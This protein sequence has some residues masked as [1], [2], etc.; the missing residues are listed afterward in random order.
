MF[1]KIIAFIVIHSALLMSAWAN[2]FSTVSLHGKVVTPDGAPVPDVQVVLLK[3]TPNAQGE[4]QTKGPVGRVA[5]PQGE[6]LF[7]NL[8]VEEHARYRLGTRVNGELMSSDIFILDGTQST[9]EM[10]LPVAAAPR[11]EMMPGAPSGTHGQ[12]ANNNANAEPVTIRGKILRKD[13]SPVPDVNVVLLKFM[14]DSTGELQTNG[15]LARVLAHNGE[16]LFEKIPQDVK[17]AYQLGTSIDGELV[18]TDYFFMTGAT[19]MEIDLP[20]PSVTENADVLEIRQESVFLE[21]G[22]GELIVTE[23]MNVSNGT[24][25]RVDT[26]RHPILIKMPGGYTQFIMH[27]GANENEWSVVEG[28]LQLN[29]VFKPGTSQIVFQYRLPALWGSIS[30]EKIF[31]DK[32]QSREIFIQGTGIRLNPGDELKFQGK[33]DFGD[34]VFLQW[35]LTGDHHQTTLEVTGLPVEQFPFILVGIVVFLGSMGG[36]VYFMRFR[37]NA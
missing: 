7:E 35:T 37:L 10:N 31:P 20:I 4:M 16:Y 13:G 2:P 33:Q 17:A 34:R 24:G 23:V 3:F 19:T 12:L 8:P 15:P 6:Y 5:A 32:V 22:T 30:F 25:D 27:Q 11:T 29:P 26:K 18:S 14:I 36:V 1:L 9:V 28:Y 21:S